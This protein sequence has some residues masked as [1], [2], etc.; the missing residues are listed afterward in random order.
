M[1]PVDGFQLKDVQPLLARMRRSGLAAETVSSVHS[2]LRLALAQA[3]RWDMATRN[4]AALVD[5]PRI[6]REDPHPLSPDEAR[7]LL[8]AVADYRLAA[9][10]DLSIRL[11]LRQ[12]EALGLCWR[13]V[14]L[15]TGHLAVRQQLQRIN[16][17]PRLVPPKSERSR[18]V[19]ELTPPIVA[20]LTVH[21]AQQVAEG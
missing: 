11:G 5:R 9:I 3:V 1:L 16:A 20:A 8:I 12:G 17:Q 4:V 7:R 6:E 15:E 2:V 19:V 10:Y 21:R 18:C 14:D 13:D